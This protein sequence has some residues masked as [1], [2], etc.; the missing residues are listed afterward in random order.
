M[1]LL[2]NI[3]LPIGIFD[4]GVGGLTVLRALQRALPYENFLYLGDT[5]RLP[6][7][8][9]SAQTVKNYALNATEVFKARGIKLLVVACNTATA[10]ALP[11]LQAQFYPIPVVGVIEPGARATLNASSQ[12]GPIVVLATE[13]TVKGKAYRRVFF[14][15]APTRE[16]IEY[17]CQLMVAL[18]EEGW[19]QGD[20]VEKIILKVLTPLFNELHHI[21]PSCML[22]GCTHFPVLKK[23][24]EH[25]VGDAIE[26][27]DPA[28]TVAKEVM[29]LL[30]QQNLMKTS[31]TL[32]STLL[33]ATDNIERF[34][35]VAQIFL[36]YTIDGKDVELVSLPFEL[37]AE[38]T[39]VSLMHSERILDNNAQLHSHIIK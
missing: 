38:H 18:A 36:G 10:V 17:P 22:L 3:D 34:A 27:V 12:E 5:A 13:G 1:S 33:M 23:A 20:L 28:D 7:G 30:S 24:I 35:R 15:I 14:A 39:A 9:K 29:I 6:Y 32:G 11:E 37:S 26:I 19:C 31:L 25:V 21:K 8:T 2:D 4:S 16:I